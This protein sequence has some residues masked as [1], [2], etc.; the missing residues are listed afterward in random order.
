MTETE[1][2]LNFTLRPLLLPDIPRCITIY[3]AA[4]Q[5]PHS[6]ACWPRVP[7]IRLW[8]ERMISTE[9]SEPGAHF[10]VAECV[11]TGLIA[12]WTKWQ[13]PKPGVAPDT[14]LPIWPAEADVRLCN[15]TFGQWA[16]THRDIMGTRGH[17]CE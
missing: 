13:A 4:F 1:N 8:W 5:N 3:F 10:L 16:R 2:T 9:L 12:G 6:L 11:S 14:T 15:E 17:W 7:G